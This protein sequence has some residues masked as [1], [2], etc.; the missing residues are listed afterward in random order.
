[1]N[2]RIAIRNILIA[3]A[4]TIMLPGCS[5]IKVPDF[6]TNGKLS[7]DTTHNDYLQ[8][9]SESFLPIHG[10]SDMIGQA[11][12]FILTILN[13]TFAPEDIQMFATGFEQ[14]KDLIDKSKLMLNSSNL[15]KAIPIVANILEDETPNEELVFFINTTK[16]LSVRNLM[17]SEY[18][19]TQ[20]LDYTLVPGPS[21][22]GCIDI[23]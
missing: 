21:F 8:N 9:I 2:R 22:E 16:D 17:T 15:E 18:Y 14:Y 10:I 11:Q 20:Y 23:Q 1:M 4:G 13:D 7:L 5:K 3:S 12:D 6:I 19:M